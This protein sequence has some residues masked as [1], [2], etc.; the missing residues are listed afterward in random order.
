MIDNLS[1]SGF[2][3]A[4]GK[5]SRMGPDK[6]L[7]EF[8]GKPLLEYMISLIKPLC[9]KV[10]VSGQQL[11]YSSFGVEVVPDFKYR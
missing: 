6:A 9:D 5:S 4:G 8:Q 7:L 3:L 10:V 11:D 1:I 2:I